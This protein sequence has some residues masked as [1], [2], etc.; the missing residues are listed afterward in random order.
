MESGFFSTDSKFRRYYSISWCCLF[1]KV[2]EFQIKIGIIIVFYIKF[3]C[4]LNRVNNLFFFR[5]VSI[6]NAKIVIIRE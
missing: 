5:N 3:N 2:E 1:I 6:L 4:I